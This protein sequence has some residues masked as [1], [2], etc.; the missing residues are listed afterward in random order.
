MRDYLTLSWARFSKDVAA[1][2]LQ[3]SNILSHPAPRPGDVVRLDASPKDSA[4]KSD[5][6]LEVVARFPGALDFGPGLVDINV[7]IHLPS[8]YIQLPR[9]SDLTS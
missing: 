5:G 8:Y 9:R 3:I 2:T 6:A 4:G 1:H 7:S